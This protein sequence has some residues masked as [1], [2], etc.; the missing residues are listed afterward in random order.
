MIETEEDLDTLL[1]SQGIVLTA[2]SAHKFVISY[3]DNKDSAEITSI[4]V[5]NPIAAVRGLKT[6]CDQAK[7][8]FNDVD[9]HLVGC[10]WHG[11]AVAFDEYLSPWLYYTPPKDVGSSN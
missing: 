11:N 4:L 9:V 8:P 7:L 5:H 6:V 3:V 10:F 2:V 1:K